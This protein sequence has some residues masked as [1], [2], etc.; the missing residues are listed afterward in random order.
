MEERLKRLRKAM[1]HGSFNQM[2]FT[3]EKKQMIKRGIEYSKGN[4]HDILLHILQLLVDE[5]TGHELLKNLRS[6]GINQ[7]EERHGFLYTALHKMEQDKML[8]SFWKLEEKNYKL[9]SRGRK[10]LQRLEE[11]KSVKNLS[12][13]ALLEG[14]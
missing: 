12:F 2:P 13:N 9:S 1:D 14:E 8:D 3:E 5:K 7:Y 6:R 10:V 4:D 11:G